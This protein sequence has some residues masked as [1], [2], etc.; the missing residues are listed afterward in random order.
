M[1]KEIIEVIQAIEQSAMRTFRLGFTPFVDPHV[2]ETVTHS[3]RDLFPKGEI[4]PESCDTEVLVERL[5]SGEI[6][7]ALVTLPIASDGIAVQPV[8]HEELV[9]CLT[10]GRC[11]G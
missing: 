4:G 11:L 3:Y 9:V 8:M 2:L 10:Q 1:R 7:A 5:R 6:D